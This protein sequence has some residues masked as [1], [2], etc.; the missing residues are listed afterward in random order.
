MDELAKQEKSAPP[1]PRY[2]QL[3]LQFR[4]ALQ[5]VDDV[6]LKN[7]VQRLHDFSIVP[8]DEETKYANLS[9]NVRLF[10]ITEMVYEKDEYATYKFASVFN[11]LSTTDCAVFIILDSDGEKTD[12]YMGIRAFDPELTPN[13]LK[14][15]LKNAMI[16]QFPGIK[17]QEY[18]D[19]EMHS[20]LKKKVNNISVVSCVANS[21]DRENKENRSFVQG[22]EKLAFAM[23]GERYTAVI[24]AN[25][26]SQ[27]QL[28]QTRKSYED[29]YSQ[30]S[31]F[32]KTQAAYSFNASENIS[33]SLS[34]SH[35]EGTTHSISRSHT[36][37]TSDS[38]SS[39]VNVSDSRTGKGSI[40]AA[41][42]A[43]AAGILGSA[44]A[45]VTG[46]LSMVVGGVVSGGLGLLGTALQ[47]RTHSEGTSSGESHSKNESDTTGSSEG[48][49]TS[50]T[51]TDTQT[52]GMTRGSGENITFH[53]E[54]KTISNMLQR[55]DLQLKRLQ[56]F[57]SLGM[58]ECAAYFMSEKP[59]TAEI[60]AATYK[61]L[62]RGENS[63]VEVCAVN[64]WRSF[65]KEE[66]RQ[67]SEYALNLIHP[68]F[69]YPSAAGEI[70][71]NPCSLVS[72]NELAIHMGLPRK[73]VCGLPVIEHADFGKE[74]VSYTHEQTRAAVNLGRVFH[75]GSECKNDVRLDR[76]SLSMHTFITG[77]TGS[78]KSNTVYEI[79]RQLDTVGI[80]FLVVEPAKGEYKNV[81]G[82]NPGV[83]VFGT[84]PDYTQLLRINPFRFPKGIHVLEH[85][86]RLI[87]IFN[88]CWPMY[89]AMPAVLKQAVLQA[90]EVCGWD[91]QSSRNEYD[92]DLFPTF[93]D[94]C[95]E[96]ED[97]IDH[98]AYDQEVKS[99]YKGSLQTRIQSLAN[100]LNGQIFTTDE[101]DNEVLFDQ[102]VIVDLS[103]I[104]SLETKS[105][106]MGI[107][108][109][110]LNERRM[111]GAEGMNVPLRHVTVLEEAHNILK[112]T[113][114][115]DGGPEGANVAGKS[116]E[117]LSN[118]IAEMRT[119]GEGFIIADQSPGAVDISAVRNTNTKIIMRLPEEAD[120]RLAGRS[121][122]LRE[123]QLD[124]IAKLPKGVAVVYQND[125]LE[126]VLCKIKK[127][128]GKEIPYQAGERKQS[129]KSDSKWFDKELI[130][131]LLKGRVN[132]ALEVDIDRM[133][134]ILPA[135]ELSTKNKIGVLRLLREYRETGKLKIWEDAWFGQLSRMA[136]DVLRVKARVERHV[137]ESED[138]DRLTDYLSGLVREQID[139]A[140]EEISLAA[141]QCLMREYV[142]DHQED[143][144]IYAQWRESV[145]K[146]GGIA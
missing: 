3:D 128:A 62:M 19:E 139:D 2:E 135:A 18:L 143:L 8:L 86:D 15:T 138:Y 73:S 84:N 67:L 29:I 43:S 22:L 49:S 26:A 102:N 91:L 48:R 24:L 83:S 77:S 56:E 16:G 132:E 33:Q 45:P 145:M 40:A 100:G 14:D 1:V 80:N 54:D 70:R 28:D 140:S 17:I 20:L 66:V 112:R 7:Y 111:S 35:T 55:I 118:A 75:M 92:E 93:R 41:G 58:W 46:G 88:V 94:L 51:E 31:P 107:L 125:W 21:K 146:R 12:F 90:Y 11:A 5:V 37:G 50:D 78:G 113:S 130:R 63:G 65:E 47:Q 114:P 98:S 10:K 137:R 71:V 57:E 141:C 104:G 120:R 53:M 105:L 76:N 97:V 133:E 123:D 72:G 39:S 129:G 119:Y 116:V 110:R 117:M 127:F 61:A 64:S 74:V 68:V 60:A 136:G 44:L 87:E 99:N 32:A 109:M 34:K 144:R 36:E 6:V 52:K 103:R 101:V 79:L 69:S 9:A 124:E 23:Q 108:V 95:T 25:A 4:S 59:H 38:T 82:H 126:P 81:F 85:V 142:S 30:L 134:D 13:I 131:L 122:A 121:A 27:Q 115:G 106:I 96:L 89:A 42:L